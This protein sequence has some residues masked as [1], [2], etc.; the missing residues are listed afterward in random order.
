MG[1][2]T[3]LVKHF[4][5]HNQKHPVTCVTGK[6]FKLSIDILLLDS[7]YLYYG[8]KQRTEAMTTLQELQARQQEIT[9]QIAELQKQQEYIAAQIAEQAVVPSKK[10][11]AYDIAYDLAFADY[12][13]KLQTTDEFFSFEMIEYT[14]GSN[15]ILVWDK[16]VY[17]SNQS[18]AVVGDKVNARRLSLAGYSKKR[19]PFQGKRSLIK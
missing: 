2:M 19:T 14:D 10:E 17:Y 18:V 5:W 3:L 9:N 16:K 11:D 1:F 6:Y 15:S 8:N 13:K 12:R 7:L 4:Y